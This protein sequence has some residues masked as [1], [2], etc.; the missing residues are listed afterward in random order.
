MPCCVCVRVHVRMCVVCVCVCVRVRVVCV[1]ACA[2]VCVC[3]YWFE[4]FQVWSFM[5]NWYSN[6]REYVG[7]IT[8]Q[9]TY[10]IEAPTERQRYISL[11]WTLVNNL[12]LDTNKSILCQCGPLNVSLG[13]I[14]WVPYFTTLWI[15][16]TIHPRFMAPSHW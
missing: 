9:C 13:R 14:R 6:V 5:K 7:I 15:K 2:R 11:H 4:S 10:F 16:C 8:I 3:N 1:W 12:P